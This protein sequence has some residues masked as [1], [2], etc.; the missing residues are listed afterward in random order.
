MYP[1][2]K[3]RF[4]SILLPKDSIFIPQ[5]EQTTGLLWKNSTFIYLKI[6]EHLSGVISQNSR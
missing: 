1:K 6:P 5:T 3:E 2:W 4:C